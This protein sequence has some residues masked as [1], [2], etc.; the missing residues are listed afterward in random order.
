MRRLSTIVFVAGITV[1]LA[2]PAAGAAGGKGG[3]V[4]YRTQPFDAVGRCSFTVHGDI[5]QDEEEVRT[6]AT[7]PDGSPRIQEFRGPL[8]I[9]FTNTSNGE[10]AVRDVSGYGRLESKENGGSAWY[11]DGGAAIGVPIGNTAYPSGEYIVHGRFRYTVAPDG[12]RD[13]PHLHADVEN[14]CQTLA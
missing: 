10:S 2:A 7:F 13:F 1:V 5:V 11:F 14:L 4:P 9:R 12:T 8:V 6:D 3:W